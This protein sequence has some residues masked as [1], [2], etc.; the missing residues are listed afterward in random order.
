MKAVAKNKF[1]YLLVKEGIN[2]VWV[3]AW[4]SILDKSWSWGLIVQIGGSKLEWVGKVITADV[5]WGYAIKESIFGVVTLWLDSND[6]E[7]GRGGA[8][9]GG[10]L[11]YHDVTVESSDEWPGKFGP[12]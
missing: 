8:G 9:G 11:R 10:K 2:P 12:Q 7:E 5:F 6:I 4:V 3:M 1:E